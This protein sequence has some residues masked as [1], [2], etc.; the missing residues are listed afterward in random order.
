MTATLLTSDELRRLKTELPSWELRGTEL[1]KD[2]QF[3]D[4]IQA[5]G[6]ISQV[7]IL[8]ESMNHHPEWRNCYS[9]LTISLTT[10]DLSGLST[11]DVTLAKKIDNL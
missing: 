9:K 7:A 5:F 3:K 4:F 6:F 2:W 11:K 1:V 8:A 10:H